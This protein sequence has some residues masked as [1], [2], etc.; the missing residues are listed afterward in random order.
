MRSFVQGGL[1]L[2]TSGTSDWCQVAVVKLRGISCLDQLKSELAREVGMECQQMTVLVFDAFE[3]GWVVATE[4]SAI[5]AKDRLRIETSPSAMADSRGGKPLHP[6]RDMIR[7]IDADLNEHH[8]CK[9]LDPGVAVDAALLSAKCWPKTEGSLEEGNNWFSARSSEEAPGRA[10]RGSDGKEAVLTFAPLIGAV[11][12]GRFHV[13]GFV[14]QGS[15]G[16]CWR[17]TDILSKKEGAEVCIKVFH[18]FNRIRNG[19]LEALAKEAKEEFE[20]WKKLK[21]WTNPGIVQLVHMTDP[22][23]PGQVTVFN[24]YPDGQGTEERVHASCH[25]V[26]TELGVCELFQYA[27]T[28]L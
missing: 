11:F 14:G 20:L 23:R 1:G 6:I 2:A 4:L 15:F 27:Q 5:K 16:Q 17:A 9:C 7:C 28:V 22:G 18:S 25:Y 24:T 19:Q 8:K 12:D 10:R 3:N 21:E 13:T 26:A